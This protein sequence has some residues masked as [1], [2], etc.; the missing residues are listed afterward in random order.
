MRPRRSS[1]PR[2]DLPY[3]VGLRRIY[4][5]PTA[6]GWVLIL[7][8]LGMLLAAVNYGLAMAYLFAFLLTGM[9]LASLLATWRNLHGVCI[10]D[11]ATRPGFAGAT[12]SFIATFRLPAATAAETLLLRAGQQGVPLLPTPGAAEASLQLPAPRRGRQALGACR[13]E[14]SAPLGLFRAW[15]PFTPRTAALVWPRPAASG[16]ALPHTLTEHAPH[17]GTSRRGSEDF[18]GLAA[19]Q[20]GESPARLVWKAQGGEIEP[21]VKRFVAPQGGPLSLSWHALTAP[22][23]E[24]R[25]AQLARWVVEADLRA[26]TYGLQLPALRIAPASGPAQRLACLNALARFGSGAPDHEPG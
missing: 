12:V 9:T 17:S 25:L 24:T 26:L 18:D 22:D 5:L 16:P 21:L 11:I 2:V 14:T 19:Y 6:H 13:L 3:T 10:R 1:A 20:A 4:I 7:L 15:S 23:A 8:L